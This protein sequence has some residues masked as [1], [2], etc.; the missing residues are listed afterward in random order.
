MDL[1]DSVQEI[2]PNLFL[3]SYEIA[4]SVSWLT[5]NKITH[6]LSIL[7]EEERIARL[8]RL[9]KLTVAEHKVILIA[10]HYKA[11]LRLYFEECVTFI[12][13]AINNN[14]DKTKRVLVH[15]LFGIS[16]SPTIVA[17]YL[18]R[19]HGMNAFQSINFINSKRRVDPS[20]TFQIQLTRYAHR[21]YLEMRENILYTNWGN[22]GPLWELVLEYFFSELLDSQL[23]SS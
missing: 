18:I 16:R 10:D 14:T 7:E 19:E 6:V 11:P 21:T 20:N 1:Q 2:I 9:L 13:T 22:L 15:C 4:T 23:D 17:A 8:K 3:G 12:K 5:R